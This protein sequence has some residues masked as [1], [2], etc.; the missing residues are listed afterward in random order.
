MVFDDEHDTHN[1][2]ISNKCMYSEQRLEVR[3]NQQITPTTAPN[4]KE[5]PTASS[6]LGKRRSSFFSQQFRKKKKH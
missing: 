5:F 2:E 3:P 4:P 1:D 6:A